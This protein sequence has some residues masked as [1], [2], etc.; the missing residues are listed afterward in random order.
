MFG[1]VLLLHLHL[2]TQAIVASIPIFLGITS[3]WSEMDMR[4]INWFEKKKTGLYQFKTTCTCARNIALDQNK[5]NQFKIILNLNYNIYNSLTHAPYSNEARRNWRG[6]E[7]ESF[8]RLQLK[9]NWNPRN[10]ISSSD[11][12]MLLAAKT[13]IQVTRVTSKYVRFE[14]GWPAAIALRK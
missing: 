6:R 11:A 13:P 10:S 7:T 12:I 14:C 3:Y 4:K 1:S 5:L 8:E 9:R 2:T